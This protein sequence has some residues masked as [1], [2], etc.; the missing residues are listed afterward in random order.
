MNTD[1]RRVRKTKKA[2]RKGLGELMLE[3]EL[4]HITVR[5]L[6]DR[7][8]VHRATFYT[9]YTD[10]DDLYEQMEE[11]AI[12]ELGAIVVCDPVHAYDGIFDL[13]VNYV[14]DNAEMYRLFLDRSLNRNFCDKISALLEQKYSEIYLFENKK[15]DL[16]EEWR[17]L[18]SYHIQGCISI[19][20]RWAKGNFAHPK[21]EIIRLV[22]IVDTSFDG[23]Q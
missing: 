8:D 3:K 10:V 19:L 1:D 15:D 4:R 6:A 22:K 18:I 11:A 14:Y 17:Y 9:H 23:L 20:T 13:I 2:L 12:E 7:A 16:T 21:D 5:E